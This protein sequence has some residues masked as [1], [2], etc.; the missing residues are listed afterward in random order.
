[1][2]RISAISPRSGMACPVGGC[3]RLTAVTAL[4]LAVAACGGGR[5]SDNGA[6]GGI[7]PTDHAPLSPTA[8]STSAAQ[9]TPKDPHL[10]AQQLQAAI[11]DIGAIVKI[12]E[13]NDQNNLIGRP[14]Q[15]D[16]AVFMQDKRLGCSAADDSS[17]C[18]STAGP[19][20]SGGPLGPTHNTAPT[21][22]RR[23]SRHSVSEP[24][25]TGSEVVS[26]FGSQERSSP[27]T[28]THT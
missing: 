15:Y 25:T 11:P 3:W 8:S 28:P 13:D 5:A 17:N 19:R 1:M 27:R 21:T 12:T 18:R 26:C 20:S 9:T 24:S 16:A 6:P 22:S 2:R 23:S 7:N 10:V 4:F 14:G